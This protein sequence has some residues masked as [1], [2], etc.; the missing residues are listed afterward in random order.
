MPEDFG[1]GFKNAKELLTG[2]QVH[3]PFTH[4]WLLPPAKVQR[5]A[6]RSSLTNKCKCVMAT[7]QPKGC[8]PGLCLLGN[9]RVIQPCDA[10]LVQGV[11]GSVSQS[12]HYIYLI[13]KRVVTAVP[14]HLTR[15]HGAMG[16][17]EPPRLAFSDDPMTDG[18]IGKPLM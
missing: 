11:S 1:W 4:R 5:L 14:H 17:V 7:S 13:I 9:R 15:R 8:S 2:P 6:I 16:P 10:R 3:P 18:I 12:T